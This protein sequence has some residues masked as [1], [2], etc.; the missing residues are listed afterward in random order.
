MNLESKQLLSSFQIGFRRYCSSYDN[1]AFLEAAVQQAFLHY[2]LQNAFFPFF[3]LIEKTYDITWL[4]GIL[5][6]D[7]FM[8]EGFVVVFPLLFG[9]SFLHVNLDNELVMPLQIVSSKISV[10]QDI[11]S[12]V[13]VCRSY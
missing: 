12:I 9:L 4:G 7:S 1:L 5:L 10:P 6:S 8:I 11:V 13:T 2:H 3:L